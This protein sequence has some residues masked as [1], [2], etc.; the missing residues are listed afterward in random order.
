MGNTVFISNLGNA[1]ARG[2]T[3]GRILTSLLVIAGL[4][5]GPTMIL[6]AQDSL[7]YFNGSASAANITVSFTQGGCDLT[8]SIVLDRF[9]NVTDASMNITFGPKTRGASDLPTNLTVKVG[10]SYQDPVFKFDGKLGQVDAFQG[11]GKTKSV[12]F[13][14]AQKTDTTTK[15]TLP[16]NAD[17][18]KATLNVEGMGSNFNGSLF[19]N[20]DFVTCVEKDP[21]TG[22]IWYGTTGGLVRMNSSGERTVIT[23][24]DGLCD[25]QVKCI[26]FDTNYVYIGTANGTCKFSKATDSMDATVWRLG[27]EHGAI[28]NETT[29]LALDSTYLYIGAGQTVLRYTKASST[30]AASW[31]YGSGLAEQ[32]Q[33]S[34][35]IVDGSKVYISQ[36][37][38]GVSIWNGAT[39]KYWGFSQLYSLSVHCIAYDSN[40]VYVGLDFGVTAFNKTSGLFTNLSTSNGLIIDST[41]CISPGPSKVLFGC[42]EGVSVF[43]SSLVHLWDWKKADLGVGMVNGLCYDAA[44]NMVYIA[45]YGNGTDRYDF[46]MTAFKS[47]WKTGNGPL[48]NQILQVQYSGGKVYFTTNYGVSIFNNALNL[49][50][51][52]IDYNSGLPGGYLITS[53]VEL[54]NVI[55]IGTSGQGVQRYDTGTSSFGTAF[56][57]SVAG[58]S[59]ASDY[60][61]TLAV[62]GT[63]LLIGS[64]KGVDFRETAS[65]GSWGTRLRA[66]DLPSEQI[67]SVCVT[68]TK[69]YFGTPGGIAVYSKATSTVTEKWT[70]VS[71]PKLLENN[72]WAIAYDQT[73]SFLYVGT[74]LG[75]NIVNSTGG[76]SSW[77]NQTHKIMGNSVRAIYVDTNYVYVGGVNM[78]VTRFTK[79]SGATTN[80]TIATRLPSNTVYCFATDTAKGILYIGTLGGIGRYNLTAGMFFGLSSASNTYPKNPGI[81]IQGSDTAK[82][83]SYTGIFNKKVT[84]IDVKTALA[85]V[86]AAS[87][88][89][90]T[91]QYGTEFVN[92]TFEVSVAATSVGVLLMSALDI[93][94]NAKFPVQGLADEINT[95]I[96]NH[97]LGDSPAV[98]YSVPLNVSSDSAGVVTLSD[99]KVLYTYFPRPPVAA[100][101]GAR[102]TYTYSEATSDVIHLVA[103]CSDPDNDIAYYHWQIYKRTGSDYAL[104]LPSSDT[105]IFDVDPSTIGSGNFSANLTVGDS[106]SKTA[107]ASVE[108][109]VLEIIIPKTYP[110]ANISSPLQGGA[111]YTTETLTLDSSGSYDEGGNNITLYKWTATASGVTTDIGTG[112]I[113]QKKFEK[114]FYLIRLYIENNRSQNDT[115]EVSISVYEPAGVLMFSGLQ[116][117][118]DGNSI[119]ISCVAYVSLPALTGSVK[120]EE[121]AFT[122]LDLPAGMTD[123]GVFFI[124]QGFVNYLVSCHITIDLTNATALATGEISGINGTKTLGL[125]DCGVTPFAKIPGSYYDADTRCINAVVNN[126]GV[127][128]HTLGVL[129]NKTE[130][131]PPPPDDD[132]TPGDDDI[133]PPVNATTPPVVLDTKPAKGATDVPTNSDIDIKF[134]MDMKD[135]ILGQSIYVTTDSGLP[136]GGSV[137]YNPT[138]EFQAKFTPS[139]GLNPKTTYTVRVNSTAKGINDMRLDGNGNGLGGEVNDYYEW[140]FTTADIPVVIDDD[141]DDDDDDD[142]QSTDDDTKDNTTTYV[143]IAVLIV[144]VLT[145]IGIFVFMLTRDKNKQ[146]KLEQDLKSAEGKQ[147]IICTSCGFENEMGAKTCKRCSKPIGQ[148]VTRPEKPA[149]S[150]PASAGAGKTAPEQAAKKLAKAIKCPTCG[151][152]VEAGHSQCQAC[153]E[154][155]FTG[156]AGVKFEGEAV[157]V[158]QDVTCPICQ[159]L[160]PKGS[161]HCPSC[162]EEDLSSAAPAGTLPGPQPQAT[163]S[164]PAQPQIMGYTAGGP[165]PKDVTCPIC[166]TVVKAGQTQCSGCGEEDFG[167]AMS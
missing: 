50:D 110:V 56:T 80:W 93:R 140:S 105:S 114:G 43:S 148:F 167:L 121:P 96:A 54:S 44:Q 130:Y 58:G 79:S 82:E 32:S 112:A 14:S 161:T 142:V 97:P 157:A 42:Q 38:G 72:T 134:N 92:V 21:A 133:Q 88:P 29:A 108:F 12:S 76:W 90:Y 33:I 94:Y 57:N 158:D 154:S 128:N 36:I 116:S 156:V 84:G 35:I 162:G 22:A 137:S 153:G 65:G 74:N 2:K 11:S 166:Q 48:D 75:V 37:Y 143:I 61:T 107:T 152:T 34:D 19:V 146:K 120:E 63:V 16:K 71:K 18:T 31:T 147:F 25:P 117:D 127:I 39:W 27:S 138:N 62:D 139:G 10:D 64:D 85:S 17:I 26:A 129:G 66:A 113:L 132:I 81:N 160:V 13:D 45:T 60:I 47:S 7:G 3:I 46:N 99:L 101:D 106:S 95:Y 6:S 30:F 136:V 104:L 69:I 4:V 165:L 78:G 89:S 23:T 159:T 68:S 77:T 53:A 123:I 119:F 115:A 9:A 124:T 15:V 164:P 70:T 20:V 40:M 55:Y 151:V 28:S 102:S 126:K 91:D 8:N 100:I 155:D 118:Q 49:F 5:I 131:K 144:V 41:Q 163:I 145:L 1:K 52:P 73:T 67:K 111:Y 125:Y 103:N 135:K 86:V 24:T 87:A 59:L 141:T 51:Q 122:I 149:T 150:A 109:Q 98:N 83:W